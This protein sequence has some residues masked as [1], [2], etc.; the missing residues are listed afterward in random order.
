MAVD[1]QQIMEEAA[2]IGEL[3]KQHPAVARYKDARR[4][5]E[6]DAEASRMMAEL[7][8]QLESLQRQAQAGMPPT[9]A[10]QQQIETLQ[11]RLVSNLKVKALNLAQVEFVDLLRKISQTIQRPLADTPAAGAPPTS[12]APA[13]AGGPRI[14]GL[15]RP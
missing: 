8:R 9:D 10:Q 7:D 3:V 15:A 13:S 1:T 12:A 4:A 5:V 6:E 2:K 14:S 11:N